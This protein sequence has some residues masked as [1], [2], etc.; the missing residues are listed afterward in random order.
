MG[1]RQCPENFKPVRYSRRGDVG[2]AADRSSRH[3]RRGCPSAAGRLRSAPSWRSSLS[4]GC[5][6]PGA[7]QRRGRSPGGAETSAPRQRS[8]RAFL[9]VLGAALTAP[10]LIGPLTIWSISSIRSEGMTASAA[11][12]ARFFFLRGIGATGSHAMPRT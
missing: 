7:S 12:A 1:Q 5:S 6:P 9:N 10:A 3:D 2:S 11:S 8:I 4:G